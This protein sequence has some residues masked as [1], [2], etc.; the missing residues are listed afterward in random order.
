[1]GWMICIHR[2]VIHFLPEHARHFWRVWFLRGPGD[3]SLT[4]HVPC[5][6]ADSDQSLRPWAIQK[7]PVGQTFACVG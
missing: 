6:T 5:A 4:N 1:M 3:M 2:D 7:A